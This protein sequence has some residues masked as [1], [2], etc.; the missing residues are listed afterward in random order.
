MGH[1]SI[2]TTMQY[3]VH[4][5]DQLAEEEVKKIDGL[6]QADSEDEDEELYTEDVDLKNEVEE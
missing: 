2:E 6:Q 1:E 3:Y 4:W 5:N